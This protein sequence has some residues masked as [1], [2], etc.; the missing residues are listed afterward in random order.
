MPAVNWQAT[1]NSY[2]TKS[3]L[4]NNNVNRADWIGFLDAMGWM[5]NSGAYGGAGGERRRV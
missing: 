4:I 3:A 1:Q 5:E 2:N